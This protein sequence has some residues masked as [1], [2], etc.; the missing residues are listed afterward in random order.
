[1]DNFSNNE[2]VIV[3]ITFVKILQQ[4]IVEL[5]ATSRRLAATNST[6][7]PKVA[8]KV[9]LT[10]EGEMERNAPA[11]FSIDEHVR[12]GFQANFDN[13][14]QRLANDSTFFEQFN[15]DKLLISGSIAEKSNDS[16]SG[17]NK[18]I[19]V[20]VGGSVALT[21]LV[22][23]IFLMER[24]SNRRGNET[25]VINEDGIEAYDLNNLSTDMMEKDPEKFSSSPAILESQHEPEVSI[26][27]KQARM[28]K[29]LVDD[30]DDEKVS[31]I[32]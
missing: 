1:M 4:S 16:V 28:K 20:I 17:K 24:K 14:T 19:V 26:L 5:N 10:V 7:K 32:V 2:E 21:V 18:W 15:K 11:N 27:Q 8:L 6:M 9:D 30:D 13:L 23:S 31:V 12:S 29:S 25:R 3:K 22:A